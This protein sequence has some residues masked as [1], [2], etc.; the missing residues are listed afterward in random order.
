MSD[1][2]S[3]AVAPAADQADMVD[4]VFPL[5]GHAIARDHAQALRDALAGLLP[6][7]RGD[8]AAGIV[9]IRLV[10]GTD[11]LS[12]LSQRA[13]LVLRVPSRRVG[14]LAAAAGAQFDVVGQRL[15]L[16]TPQRQALRPHSAMYAYRVAAP[17]P[18]EAQFMAMVAREMARLGIAAARVCGRQQQIALDG[19]QID[20]FSLLLHEM[21]PRHALR[22]QEYGLGEHRLLGCGVFVPHKSAAAA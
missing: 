16:G 15:R 3:P 22:L 19:R 4:V 7:L 21:E 11:A 13:R 18:D 14:E 6:W 12:P 1:A 2:A 17:G 20:V 9:P 8:A 10:P 5:Q